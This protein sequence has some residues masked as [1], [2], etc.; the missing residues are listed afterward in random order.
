MG[1][2]RL[3]VT[4]HSIPELKEVIRNIDVGQGEEIA[5]HALS[6]ELAR[7]VENYLRGELKKICPDL[8]T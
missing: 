8:V 5:A 6:L 3:S 4:P 1:I 7:D 2:R